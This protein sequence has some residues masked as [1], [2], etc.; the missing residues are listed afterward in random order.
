MPRVERF[1]RI[2]AAT[3][4]DVGRRRFDLIKG[5][6][7][8]NAKTRLMVVCAILMSA[9]PLLAVDVTEV[10]GDG[11]ANYVTAIQVYAKPESKDGVEGYAIYSLVGD[12]YSVL[13]WMPKESFERQFFK[14][15]EGTGQ[16][17]GLITEDTVARFIAGSDTKQVGNRGATTVVN[18]R[19][20]FDVLKQATAAE[21]Y[22]FELSEASKVSN[23]RARA[24]IWEHLGFVKQWS[25]CVKKDYL[26]K[27]E[28]SQGQEDV[29]VP[30]V[31]SE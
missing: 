10:K 30:E 15:G 4:G 28:L 14:L 29:Q 12:E 23:S 1:N 27:L 25:E 13:R 2:Q 17:A 21:T 8:L 18:T 11:L 20:G 16:E 3:S 6:K 9:R 7:M 31:V 26:D 5:L 24:A 22:A 19:I